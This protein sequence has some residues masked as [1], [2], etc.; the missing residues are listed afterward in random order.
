MGVGGGVGVRV[1]GVFERGGT[2]DEERAHWQTAARAE[3]VERVKGAPRLPKGR[4]VG[5]RLHAD[6][7]NQG[8]SPLHRV[9]N[10]LTSQLAA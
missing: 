1:A 5:S 6:R 7:G 8:G 9:R 3:V 10:L 4:A 2:V